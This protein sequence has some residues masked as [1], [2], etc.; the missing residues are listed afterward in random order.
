MS[1]EDLI[2][3]RCCMPADTGGQATAVVMAGLGAAYTLMG[4]H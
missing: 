3:L 1:S 2:A 4:A